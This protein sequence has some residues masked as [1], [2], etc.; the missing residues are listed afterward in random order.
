M[1]RLLSVCQITTAALWGGFL[2]LQAADQ[3]SW[4]DG[5]GDLAVNYRDGTWRWQVEEGRD[6]DAVVIRLNDITRKEIPANPAFSFLGAVGDPLWIIPSGQMPGIPFLGISAEATS[7]GLFVNDRFELRLNS[8]AGPGDFVLWT[9]TGT[10]S[11]TILMNSRD[12]ITDA[13]R[14]EVPV[15]GHLH[16]NWGFTSPGTYRVGFRAVGLLV[17]QAAPSESDE[18]VYTFEAS[19]LKSGEADI[20][21]A[22]ESGELEFHVH[23]EVT[24]IEFDPAH[25]ALQAGP[26]SS[27]RVPDDPDFRFLGQPGDRVYVLPQDE[28]EGVLFLGLAAGEVSQGVFAGDR[29]E[30]Q[31]INLDGPGT[32]A[33]YDVSEFGKPT[34][35]VDSGDGV[36]AADR[37]PVTAGAHAHRNW[38]FSAPGVYRVALQAKGTL[39]SGGEIRSQAA[40]FLFEVVPPSE[41]VLSASAIDGGRRILVTWQ[42]RAGVSYQLQARES[43]ASGLWVDVGPVMAGTSGTKSATVELGGEPFKIFRLSEVQP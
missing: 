23:D 6:L 18:A 8:V 36:T 7:S 4:S 30:V 10:G 13:D 34:V 29:L 19:V 38:A 1:K 33:V 9:T 15:G 39:V 26:G 11:P 21:V 3:I 28:T 20:E 32:M 2:S 16:Q 43:V 27:Q 40:T 42:S 14:T 17:G 35:F 41:L 31:L 22:Y 37:I 24:Q 12:G 5:H 25:A